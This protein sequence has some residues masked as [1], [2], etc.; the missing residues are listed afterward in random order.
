MDALYQLVADTK[1]LIESIPP[2]SIVSRT[3][4]KDE[5]LRAIVFGF[6]R[7]QELSEHTSAYAAIIQIISGEASVTAGGD[8]HELQAGSWLYMTPKLKH[9]GVAKTPLVML[10]TMFGGE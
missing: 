5:H 10:L 3:F 8:R 4:H 9:S 6:D 1:A 7:G 2:D